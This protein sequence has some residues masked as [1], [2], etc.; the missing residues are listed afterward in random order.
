[1]FWSLWRPLN[2]LVAA[3]VLWR[4]FQ[5]RSRGFWWHSRS[6]RWGHEVEVVVRGGDD[7]MHRSGM[8]GTSRSCREGHGDVG[9]VV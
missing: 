4:A 3:V 1:M 9:K 2:F 5:G 7:G 8:I 6:F